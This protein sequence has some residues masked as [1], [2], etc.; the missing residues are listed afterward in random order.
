MGDPDP[1]KSKRIMDAMLQMSK[2]DI[3]ALM[4]AYWGV[5]SSP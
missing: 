2:I 5:S 1:E 4:K 3:N